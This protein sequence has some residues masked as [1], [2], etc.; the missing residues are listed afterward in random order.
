[1]DFSTTNKLIATL[2]NRINLIQYPYVFDA[3]CKLE[4]DD[5]K[6]YSDLVK[7]TNS[8]LPEDE[9]QA[10]RIEL[11]AAHYNK[12]GNTAWGAKMLEYTFNEDKLVQR[13]ISA[14]EN[15]GVFLND[16][17][18]EFW[19]NCP[20]IENVN[21]LCNIYRERWRDHLY[22]ADLNHYDWKN[23]LIGYGTDENPLY[24][25]FKALRETGLL[26]HSELEVECNLIHIAEIVN[27]SVAEVVE[28]FYKMRRS[29]INTVD[30][31]EYK[32]AVIEP[33]NETQIQTVAAVITNKFNDQ[34]LDDVRKHFAELCKLTSKTNSSKK[35]IIT[36]DQLE[37]FIQ[38]AFIDNKPPVNKIKINNGTRDTAQIS[39]IFHRYYSNMCRVR[40]YFSSMGKNPKEDYVRLLTDYFHG[41]EYK[42]IYDNF[43]S[44]I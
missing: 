3:G 18:K 14:T 44:D 4:R 30:L 8:K 16:I 26:K 29:A 17:E 12:P 5:P 1:M 9:K 38:M 41:F 33:V 43:R 27:T 40:E 23:F 25:Q 36:T 10:K 20:D 15:T 22:E 6:L 37:Q 28:F 39:F 24:N 7:I 21:T 32:T 31:P 13:L 2:D 42:K 35:H 19:L 11:F 34:P